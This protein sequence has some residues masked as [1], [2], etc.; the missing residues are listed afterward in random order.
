MQKI[1][2]I[3]FILLLPTLVFA[4]ENAPIII[5]KRIAGRLYMNVMNDMAR[6]VFDNGRNRHFQ[7]YKDFKNEKLEKAISAEDFIKVGS[8]KVKTQVEVQKD[9]KYV[10]IDTAMPV[11]MEWSWIWGYQKI[12]LET[13]C[14][15]YQ[16][17]KDDS[18]G[19]GELLGFCKAVDLKNLFGEY[20]W[21]FLTKNTANGKLLDRQSFMNQKWKSFNFKSELWNLP[22]LGKVQTYS[23]HDYKSKYAGKE[24]D[25]KFKQG[26]TVTVIQ[27]TAHREYDY[28]TVVYDPF[29]YDSINGFGFSLRMVNDP[30]NKFQKVT[31]DAFCPT[32]DASQ[33]GGTYV[34]SDPM[35]WMKWS[36]F[37]N[38]LNAENISFINEIIYLAVSERLNSECNF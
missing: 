18:T 38:N 28:Q 3:L 9:D 4:Q 22:S 8:Y 23:L 11:V 34:M 19:K 13:Y 6:R 24:L 16:K 17:P 1:V 29:S 10:M 7:L 35:Y 27:D 2:K 14:I 21:E 20:Q 33:M 31:L 26:R 30:I 32:F 12:N 25:E 36:A 5:N 37:G 15:Y